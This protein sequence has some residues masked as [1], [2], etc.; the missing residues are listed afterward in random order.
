MMSL[1]RFWKVCSV[2]NSVNPTR[3]ND[4]RCGV[5]DRRGSWRPGE[6][7]K[8]ASVF[9][10]PPRPR[11]FLNG[12]PHYFLPWNMLFLATTLAFWSWLTPAVRHLP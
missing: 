2:S 5:R 6:A 11:A 4:S 8:P 3:M 1:R 7:L 10:F 9:V 12:L